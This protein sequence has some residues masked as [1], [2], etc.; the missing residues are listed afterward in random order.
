MKYLKLLLLLLMAVSCNG[1]EKKENLKNESKS[2]DPA[3][4]LYAKQKDRFE[5]KG[6]KLYFN[7]QL[8]KSDTVK[9]VFKILGQPKYPDEIYY[10]D[11]PLSLMLR[12]VVKK[13][14]DGHRLF[15]N[16]KDNKVYSLTELSNMDEYNNY[17]NDIY[18]YDKQGDTLKIIRKYR[19]HFQKYTPRSIADAQD[20]MLIQIPPVESSVKVNGFLIDKNTTIEE[21][22]QKLKPTIKNA[23]FFVLRGN[24]VS[25]WYYGTENDETLDKFDPRIN[26]KFNSYIRIDYVYIDDKLNAIDYYYDI[27]E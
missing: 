13:D 10:T 5:I 6:Y 8:L 15:I 4:Q 21:L 9:S 19:I 12:Y 27:L 7:D 2:H 23:D 24:T 18:M 3:A 17:G 14:K 26:T 16:K 1:Q 25:T 20:S 11:K 22:K